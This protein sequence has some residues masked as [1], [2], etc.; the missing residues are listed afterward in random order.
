MASVNKVTLLGNCG[1][2]PEMR[3]L[4]SGKAICSISIATSSKYKNQS[5]DLVEDTQWH[6][7]NFFDRLAEGERK[8]GKGAVA[9]S[10]MSSHPLSDERRKVF[11]AS[12]RK[13]AAYAPAVTP[14]QWRAI[15]DA[16]ANDPDVKEGDLF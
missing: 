5:G 1:R 2:D 8:L 11:L 15:V 12:A 16:C 9:M 13:G 14:Q 4:P 10:Y 3:Y 6:R 7:V